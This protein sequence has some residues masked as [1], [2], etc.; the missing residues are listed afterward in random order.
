MSLARRVKKKCPAHAL[1]RSWLCRNFKKTASFK[2]DV[3]GMPVT[4][5]DRRALGGMLKPLARVCFSAS[6]TMSVTPRKFVLHLGTTPT[7]EDRAFY[8]YRRFEFIFFCDKYVNL[9]GTEHCLVDQ[10]IKCTRGLRGL[11]SA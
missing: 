7:I 6:F 1:F 11:F 3:Y 5:G 4:Q 9:K 10:T 2:G 8:S